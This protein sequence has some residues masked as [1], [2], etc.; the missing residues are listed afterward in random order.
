MR[1]W[2]KHV[3]EGV[4]ETTRETSFS[5]MFRDKMKSMTPEQRD[6]RLQNISDPRRRA[7]MISTYEHG[8]D[9]PF[10]EQGIFTFDKLFQEMD[11]AL[12]LGQDWLVGTRFSLG[13]INV[14]PFAARLH[15]LNLLDVWIASRPRV[16]G[17]WK[18]AQ[19]WPSF[20]VAIANLLS[21]KQIEAMSSSASRIRQQ[22]AA[23]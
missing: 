14:I 15:Y 8:C 9:S 21:Q 6:G 16:Q 5:A 7:R 13:D 19:S 18:R 17:R 10:V 12:A 1:R 20:S 11:E 23:K 22:I 3:D 4:F 2:S